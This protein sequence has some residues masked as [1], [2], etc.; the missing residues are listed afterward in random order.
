MHKYVFGPFTLHSE[1][2]LTDLQSTEAVGIPLVLRNGPVPASLSN[3]AYQD[4]YCSATRD[5]CLLSIPDVARYLIRQ[6][7]EI[8]VE[9][10]NDADPLDVGGFLLGNVFAVA[11]HQRG[12]L[13]LHASA[14]E[15]DGGVV[16]FAGVSGA[17]KSTLAAFLAQNGHPLVADDICLLDPL[18]APGSR[19]LPMPPW[20]K[21]WRG[22]L[23]AL[24]HQV[25]GLRQT[26]SDEDKYKLPV[27]RFPVVSSQP[28]PLKALVLLSAPAAPEGTRLIELSPAQAIAGMMKYTY[29]YFLLDWLGMQNEHFANCARSLGSTPAYACERAWGFDSLPELAVS[30]RDFFRAGAT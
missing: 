22:S 1:I 25:G 21:L 29:Q 9:A 12:L 10:Q 20:L 13:P 5:E 18:A 7:S 6:G 4:R 14:V 24:G 23:V 27:S 15:M 16:A 3:P 11:C 26:F 28:L 30:L 2:E 19:V 8:T 17:G